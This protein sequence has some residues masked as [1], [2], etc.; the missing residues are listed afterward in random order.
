MISFVKKNES[1]YQIGGR[2]GA[3]LLDGN[4]HWGVL[5]A[6]KDLGDDFERVTGQP[7]SVEVNK[8]IGSTG[9]YEYYTP[10]T[11]ESTEEYKVNGP[12]YFNTSFKSL[13]SPDSVRIIAGTVGKSELINQIVSSGKLDTKAIEGK[14]ESH[15]ISLVSDPIPGVSKALV[16]AGSDKRGT[17]FGL[18]T[19][20]QLI[21]VS[22]FYWWADV[23]TA[24]NEAIF[25]QDGTQ[26]VQK[27]PSIKYRGFFINDEE[28]CITNWARERYE[29]SKWGSSF[30]SDFY[31][32]VFEL[33][34]R[35]RANYLWPTMWAGM[36]NVDDERNPALADAYGVV[37]GTSHTEPLLR[38][39]HEWPKFGKGEWQW[40][41]N[42]EQIKPYFKHGI[43]RVKNY[44]GIYN[45]GMRGYDDFAMDLPKE[46]AVK[47]VKDVIKSQRDILQQVIKDKKLED[48]PQMWCIYK[49]VQ[50][51]FEEG[52]AV[53]DDVTLLW[54]D[55]NWGNI[56]RLPLDNERQRSGGA[57]L[58]YHFD[59]VGDPRNYKWLNTTS[60]QR[61]WEQLHLAYERGADRVWIVNVGDLKPQELPMSFYFDLAYDMEKWSYNT[62]DQWI[63]EWAK[64]E[65][66]SEHAEEIAYLVDTYSKYAARRKYELVDPHTFSVVNY[67]EADSV[68]AE[69]Q[70]LETKA[71]QLYVKLS[72]AE[73]PSYFQLILHP[74][75]AAHTLYRIH[76]NTGKNYLY[77]EQ[78]RSTTNK[79][80][81]LVLA[82]F[83]RDKKIA[84]EYH[85]LLDGKWNHMMEQ[86]HLGYNYWQQPMRDLLPPLYWIQDSEATKGKVAIGVEGSFASI[87]G[88]DRYHELNGTVLSLPQLDPFGPKSRY[89]DV[90]ARYSGDQPQYW[91]LIPQ[92]YY[93]KITP[94]TGVVTGVDDVDSRAEVSVDWSSVPAG[95][96]IDSLI[97]FQVADTKE[98]LESLRFES[99]GFHVKVPVRNRS[100]PAGF[101]GF[102]ESDGQITI[103]AENYTSAGNTDTAK[104]VTIKGLGHTSSGVTL[105]PTSI[106]TQ[107]P[108]HGSPYLEFS[109]LSFTDADKAKVIVYSAPTLNFSGK[110]RPMKYAIAIDN[111]EHQSVELAPVAPKELIPEDWEEGVANNMWKRSSLHTITSGGHK[112]RIWAIEPGVVIQKIVI[113]LG[114]VR[115]SYLGPPESR[116]V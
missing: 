65:F 73:K 116:I 99:N 22:P 104:Y 82:D 36:F 110:D 61:M 46:E 44:E 112:L 79:T 52:L 24:K 105:W 35:L 21:G 37:M 50:E 5:R 76:V 74:I 45:L 64:R 59:Y 111:E 109:F 78:K 48:I 67:R 14:W 19:I 7:L 34:L 115:E 31:S 77:A 101:K 49:E 80:A 106:P 9:K 68:I 108:S 93:I 38:A 63:L 92:H 70:D 13:A 11:H 3:I 39:C 42:K 10:V 95:M 20:S 89:I 40:N 6:A 114:G 88:D 8:A 54:C 51:Y 33:V 113:D 60:L 30:N 18:Y 81:E 47:V 98:E 97:C 58:Y 102:V 84:D 17:I 75:K 32:H 91:S 15:V 66:G 103:N 43:E 62:I 100:V 107:D 96:T 41:I 55:D 27:T 90:F 85:S 25:V 28:P 94:S 71:E 56:R 57:G 12:F 72:E 1:D 16:I 53:P 87:P 29:K 23:V 2:P 83:K 4:E 69:W 86:T 26:Q